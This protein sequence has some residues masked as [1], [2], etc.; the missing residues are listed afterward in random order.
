[1]IVHAASLYKHEQDTA[2]DTWTIVHNLGMYPCVDVYTLIDGTLSKVI[3]DE[4]T[5]VNAATCVVTFVEPISGFAT[6][7]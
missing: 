7:C 3:P 6:V 4:V 5:Y 1:M 2:S